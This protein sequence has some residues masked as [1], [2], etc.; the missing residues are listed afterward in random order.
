M[1][2]YDS[3]EKTAV[4]DADLLARINE[5]EREAVAY[6]GGSL[7][8][9]RELSIEYYYG[10]I[11]VAAPEGRSNVVSTDVRDAVD[12]MLPDLLDVFLSSNDIVKFEPEGPEDDAGASQA[13][14]ACN[15]VFY[16]QNNGALILYEWFK[17]AMLE[18]NGVV[19]FWWEDS[20][21]VSRETYEGLTDLQLQMVQSDPNNEIVEHTM[22]P[23]GAP[24]ADGQETQLHDITLAVKNKKGKV[25]IQAIPPEEFLISMSHTSLSLNDCCFC[26]HRKLMTKSELMDMGIEVTDEDKSGNDSAIY[27][28][29]EALAR[30]RFAEERNPADQ[31]LSKRYSVLE[32]YVKYDSDGDGYDELRRVVRVGNKIHINEEAEVVP[33]AAICPVIMP[34]RFY[35]L[36]IADLVMDIQKQKSV[37]WRGM[38]DSMYL[39]L[40]PRIGVQENMVNLD[41]LLVSRPGGIVRFKGRPSDHWQPI[42]T[43]FLGQQAFPMV[44]YMDSVKESRTGFTRYSQGMNADSLNK[45]ATGI[46]LI[47]TASGKRM[48]LIARMFAETGVKDLFKGILQ[49][50]TKYNNKTMVMRLR[51]QWT[52]VDPRQWKTSWDMTVNVGLGTGDKTQQLAMLQNV[53]GMQELLLKGGKTHMVNDLNLFNSAKRLAELS[54]FKHEE[55]FFSAPSEE[56]KPPQAPPPPEVMK[57]EAE[58][59]EAKM[60]VASAE[61]IK[62]AEMQHGETVANIQ[63]QTNIEVAKINAQKDKDIAAAN[64]AR[65][66][67]I[68]REKLKAE[69]E[70][71]IFKANL[72]K[73]VTEDDRKFQ[74]AM[75]HHESHSERVE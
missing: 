38:F 31:T 2:N 63:S 46:S 59:D 64:I 44:E 43:K 26:A 29:P 47:T 10:N 36:S 66:E 30:R 18:K 70:R 7:S 12:G 9:E 61:R 71:E 4:G 8:R 14:D 68:A 75:K 11:D 35:G 15:Y 50:L 52:E 1:A 34:F 16:R 37:T 62:G 65:D 27:D 45:T 23:S 51:N 57:L 49:L 28:T 21:S 67:R 42:E 25:C 41:D 74:V 3:D 40:N 53:V 56:N 72:Q 13:T 20:E 6:Y 69:A 39:S 58:Q 33:F 48:K 73:E 5:E 60:K 22:V 32:A 17:T 54:G 24:T 19:K 55:E